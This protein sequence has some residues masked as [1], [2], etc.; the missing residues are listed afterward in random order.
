ML[1]A[2]GSVSSGSTTDKAG[3]QGLRVAVLT[4][5]CGERVEVVASV[6][7]VQL[8]PLLG[9]PDPVTGP[10]GCAHASIRSTFGPTYVT[11]LAL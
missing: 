2:L 10:G 11:T 7:A 6:F 9:D 5:I 8:F 4:E 1:R 3:W